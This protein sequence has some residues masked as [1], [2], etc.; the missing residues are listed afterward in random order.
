M[1]SPRRYLRLRRERRRAQRERSRQ[2]LRQAVL[3]R[4]S[5]SRE[6]AS[7]SADAAVVSRA[8]PPVVD[9]ATRQV[10]RNSRCSGCAVPHSACLLSATHPS[11]YEARHRPTGRAQQRLATDDRQNTLKATRTHCVSQPPVLLLSP[12]NFLLTALGTPCA[13]HRSLYSR[14]YLFMLSQS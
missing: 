3:P 12:S 8:L 9:L 4:S 7:A 1:K 2:R 5:R 11:T 6:C 13:S 10:E 14:S